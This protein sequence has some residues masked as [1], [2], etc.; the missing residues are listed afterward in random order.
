MIYQV[1]ELKGTVL[2]LNFFLSE[3]QEINK[4]EVL[5]VE[6]ISENHYFIYYKCYSAKSKTW[7]LKFLGL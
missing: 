1:I 3:L 5:N 4:C 2:E 6:R 7:F